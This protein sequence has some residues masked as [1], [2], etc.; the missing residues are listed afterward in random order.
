MDDDD[1]EPRTEP[2][3]F[4]CVDTGKEVLEGALPVWQAPSGQIKILLDY[5]RSCGN[6]PGDEP[7]MSPNP[8]YWDQIEDGEPPF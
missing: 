7:I 3:C 1:G 5:C 8:H 6:W 2:Y 4:D